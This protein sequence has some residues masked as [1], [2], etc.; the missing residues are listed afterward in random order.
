M[1]DHRS[2]EIFAGAAGVG[3]LGRWVFSC[4]LGGTNGRVVVSTNN[5]N[6]RVKASGWNLSPLVS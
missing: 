5:A 4:G 2:M 6:V 3:G 1:T